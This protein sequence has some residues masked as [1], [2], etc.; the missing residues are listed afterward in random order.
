MLRFLRCRRPEAELVCLCV[1]PEIVQAQYGIPAVPIRPPRRA[2][3]SWLGKLRA[4]LADQ[5]HIYRKLGDVDVLLVPGTGIM[6]DFNERPQG[7]P[8]SVFLICMMAR[9][10]GRKIAFVS[11]G[12]G[13]ILH[14]LSR[15]LM[16]SAAR[17]ATYRSYRDMISKEFMAGIG[18]D[19]R[20][21]PVY[22]DLVFSLPDP[23]PA[24]KQGH[25]LTVGLGVMAYYGWGADRDEAIYRA[26]LGKLT[27][28]ASWLLEQGY[29]I[30][31][32]IGEDSDQSAVADLTASLRARHAELSEGRIVVGFHRSL[33][34]LM[35]QIAEVDVVVATRFHNVLCALKLGKPAI[36]LGYARKNDVLMQ[37][38]G[39]GDFC[40]HVESFDI[41]QLIRHFTQVIE[42]RRLYQDIVKRRAA[43]L[44]D[45]LEQQ[46]HFLIRNVI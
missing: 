8:Y 45:Q 15:W 30:R 36:S 34:E 4:R 26:Y 1:A 18:L 13:P 10:R 38:M 14:P 2:R 41:D 24:Q 46:E 28:F 44:R 7:M 37:A 19:V 25:A 6:D 35:T 11:I 9:L 39:L 31:L 27:E 12:A 22:P 32:L 17:V 43:Q 40:Q 5:R 29:D 23:E 42:Q 21:D 3:K 20:G 16:K 33:H